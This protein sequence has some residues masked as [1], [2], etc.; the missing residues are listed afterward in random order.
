MAIVIEEIGLE[1]KHCNENDDSENE[2]EDNQDKRGTRI[3]I[4]SVLFSLDEL[5]T[6]TETDIVDSVKG[7]D[8]KSNDDDINTDEDV[9]VNVNDDDEKVS[10]TKDG[11]DQALDVGQILVKSESASSSGADAIENKAESENTSNEQIINM[12]SNGPLENH[13]RTP[14]DEVNTFKNTGTAGGS[15]TETTP[16]TIPNLSIMK[17]KLKSDLPIPI[18]MMIKTLPPKTPS[19]LNRCIG[20]QL[21]CC[22]CKHVRP[23]HDSTFLEIPIVPTAI[24]KCMLKSSAVPWHKINGVKVNSFYIMIGILILPIWLGS[25]V[26]G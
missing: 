3:G 15:I 13:T 2:N 16:P 10:H 12:I 5:S 11:E 8:D 1:K 22:E 21:Q 4:R 18:Q 17:S 24:S 9:D 26:T 7:Q 23:I 20:S 6:G 14:A 19:P 25:F